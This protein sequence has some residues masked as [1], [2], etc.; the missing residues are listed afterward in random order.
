MSSALGSFLSRQLVKRAA[1]L[2]GSSHE[3]HLG[4]TVVEAEVALG[5]V[6]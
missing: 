6:A 3:L 2:A 4:S 5:K 1:D